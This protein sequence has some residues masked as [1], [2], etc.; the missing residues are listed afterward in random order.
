[1]KDY[2]KYVNK[3][4]EMWLAKMEAKARASPPWPACRAPRHLHSACISAQCSASSNKLLRSVAPW[5]GGVPSG[6]THAVFATLA[7]LLGLTQRIHPSLLSTVPIHDILI[8]AGKYASVEAF[9]KDIG[10]IAAAARSYNTNGRH[11]N[12]G[13]WRLKPWRSCQHYDSCQRWGA[14]QH[15][16]REEDCTQTL[17]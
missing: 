9:Q 17:R 8:Q 7:L 6:C 4:D 15:V 13:E 5:S 10:A 14:V 11:R 12:P 3:K 16:Q 1:M 2:S